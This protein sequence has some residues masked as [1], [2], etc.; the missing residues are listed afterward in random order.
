MISA[1]ISAGVNWS[2]TGMKTLQGK[3]HY[4]QQ[5]TLYEVGLILVSGQDHPFV[6]V[7][8]TR[9]VLVSTCLL[10]TQISGVSTTLVV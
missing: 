9:A 1:S 8:A 5:S 10:L 3:G 7:E 2:G 6:N 4:Q